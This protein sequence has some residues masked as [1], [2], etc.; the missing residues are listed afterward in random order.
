M[1]KIFLFLCTIAFLCSTPAFALNS[2]QLYLPDGTY[3]WSDQTWIIQ[4]DGSTFTLTALA[5]D[6]DLAPIKTEGDAFLGSATNAILSIALG[7]SFQGPG[8]EDPDTFASLTI[9]DESS[10]TTT[11][12]GSTWQWGTPPVNDPNLNPSADLAPHGIYPTW[13]YEYHFA[14]DDP[15]GEGTWDTQDTHDPGTYS[16]FGWREDFLVDIAGIDPL[17]VNNVHFD[18]YTLDGDGEIHKFAPFS[19]DAQAAPVPEPATLL[20]L[21]SGLMGF[22]GVGRKKFFKK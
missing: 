2:L 21:G 5:M 17:L 15:F 13:Y 12:P 6:S 11:I 16:K 18:L 19:H 10:N 8:F 14:F 4:P 7:G 22:A 1:K 9:T 3:T 20:L